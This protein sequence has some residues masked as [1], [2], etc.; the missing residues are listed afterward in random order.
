MH[1]SAWKHNN[2]DKYV[3]NKIFIYE[4]EVA[5]TNTVQILRH[6]ILATQNS[7][8][9]IVW[10]K[11]GLQLCKLKIFSTVWKTSFN[12][13]LFISSIV[14]LFALRFSNFMIHLKLESARDENRTVF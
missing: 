14:I 1:V 5:S 12:H 9:H 6:T 10:I 13:G 2:D 4:W 7:N 3:Q 11:K 8:K